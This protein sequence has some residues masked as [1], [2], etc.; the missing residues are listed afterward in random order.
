MHTVC[1]ANAHF[2]TRQ[3]NPT[4]LGFYVPLAHRVLNHRSSVG[5][6]QLLLV[7]WPRASHLG[8]ELSTIQRPPTQVG[9]SWVSF[10]F[11]FLENTFP[12]SHSPPILPFLVLLPD[13]RFLSSCGFPSMLFTVPSLP[14]T[15]SFH[16]QV[17]LSWIKLSWKLVVIK[18]QGWLTGI[19][20]VL[21]SHCWFLDMFPNRSSSHQG[22]A[23]K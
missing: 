21:L 7:L 1:P 23:V 2:M 19:S 14:F 13:Q 10:G 5:G 16:I 18:I 12:Y 20:L 17:L 8:K 22:N 9:H 4:M 11:F 3:C 6:S 15:W